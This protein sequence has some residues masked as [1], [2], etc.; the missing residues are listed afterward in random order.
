VRFVPERD[1]VKPDLEILAGP[2]L[3]IRTLEGTPSA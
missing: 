1:Q 3:P 2:V